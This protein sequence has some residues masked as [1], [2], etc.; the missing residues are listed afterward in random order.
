MLID[1]HKYIFNC[2]YD[3]M[4]N[5]AYSSV[6][7]SRIDRDNKFSHNEKSYIKTLCMGV[8][9]NWIKLEYYIDK[10][11]NKKPK[12]NVKILLMCAIYEIEFMDDNKDYLTVNHY[13]ES[14]KNLFPHAKNFVN[15]ILRQ[16]LRNKDL[17]PNDNSLK[18]LSIIYS[19]PIELVEV[20][21]KVYGRKRLE[22]ILEVNQSVPKIYFRVNQKK[23]TRTKLLEILIEEGF[24]VKPSDICE[25]AILVEKFANNFTSLPSFLNGYYYIQDISSII[26]INTVDINGNEK[27]LDV[28]AAPGGKSLGVA[29]KLTSGKLIAQDIYDKKLDR[30][31][32]NSK[33]LGIDI[34]T[35]LGDA[36][37]F[38]EDY[39]EKFDVVIADLPCS[40]LGIISKKPEIKYRK[41]TQNLKSMVQLQEE[42]LNNVSKY[43]KKDGYLYY[44]TCTILPFEN[45]EQI[46]CFIEKNSNFK[47]V[48]L[49]TKDLNNEFVNLVQDNLYSDGFFISKLMRL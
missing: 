42:I 2:I 38:N 13:V 7:T 8:V 29:E 26:M 12:K 19:H 44:S 23:I 6:V 27:V 34:E 32:D 39:V 49:E 18:S 48:S 25:N 43:V 46:R 31:L 10:L 30:L 21:E 33:R 37:V 22:K 11:S 9:K 41:S 45:E 16:F 5:D 35:K 40:G 17:L 1:T 15:A 47:V 24:I 36:T 3:I 28:A 20:L 4:Y 14:A